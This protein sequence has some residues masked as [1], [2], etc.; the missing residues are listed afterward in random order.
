MA[1][2]IIIAHYAKSL[3]NIRGDMIKAFVGMG[4]RVT[5]AAP[6]EGFEREMEKLGARYVRVPLRN[7]GK[8]PLVDM[9]TFISLLRLLRRERPEKVLS[10]AVK[11]IIYGSLAARVV[12]VKEIYALVAG[13]GHA[14]RGKGGSPG[15]FYRGVRFLFRKALGVTKTVFVQNQEDLKLLKIPGNLPP[16]VKVVLV[17]GSGVDLERFAQ[18]PLPSQDAPLSFLLVGRLLLE[19]GV[20]EFVEAARRLKSRYP[21][22][23]FLLLGPM[24]NYPTAIKPGQVKSWVDEG[25]IDYLGEVDDVREYLAR[26]AVFVLPSYY[27]EGIPRSAL[28]ALAVGRPVITT[29]HPGCR[30]TVN[31]GENGFLVPP[32]N[33]TALA[34]SM[35]HFLLHPQDVVAMGRRSRELAEKRFDVHRVNRILMEEMNL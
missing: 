19:K 32:R 5:A 8:N 3:V 20:G 11:P 25:I 29:D 1:K 16:G 13:L 22:A 21:R 12:G 17:D 6:E 23:T 7:T 14:F 35:E 10:Y 33:V 15:F 28:E 4:H 9:V 30:E 24:G 34:E 31:H 27:G 2:I 26:S 18:V